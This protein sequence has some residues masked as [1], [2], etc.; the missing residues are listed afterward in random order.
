VVPHHN[1]NPNPHPDHRVMSLRV[2]LIKWH[3]QYGQVEARQ[4]QQVPEEMEG[5][6]QR[7]CRPLRQYLPLRFLL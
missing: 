4:R 3:I 2:D 1:H 6:H 7:F 5:I